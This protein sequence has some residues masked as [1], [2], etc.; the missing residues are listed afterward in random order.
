M[1]LWN[2][3]KHGS[4][5]WCLFCKLE[6]ADQSPD[7]AY[8]LTEEGAGLSRE[9]FL[10]C[11]VLKISV[12]TLLFCWV[13]TEIWSPGVHVFWAVWELKA[14]SEHL[15]RKLVVRLFFFS[16]NLHLFTF[17]VGLP[18]VTQWRSSP[19]QSGSRECWSS[20]AWRPE[21]PFPATNQQLF[22]GPGGPRELLCPTGR[23]WVEQG[24]GL[25]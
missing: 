19:G 2:F 25:L 8:P 24:R 11:S 4:N 16:R 7:G 9:I 6:A 20:W 18:G 22:G 1:T 21:Q 17:P 13:R 5:R 10:C 3:M 14:S 23:G 12:R 15:S